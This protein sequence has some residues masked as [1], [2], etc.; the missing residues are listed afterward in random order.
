MNSGEHSFFRLY[1]DE[2]FEAFYDADPVSRRRII[3]ANLM[4]NSLPLF[5]MLAIFRE[6]LGVNLF[7]AYLLYGGFILYLFSSVETIAY[8]YPRLRYWYKKLFPYLLFLFA[9]AG[10]PLGIFLAM[11]GYS[12]GSGSETVEL[13]SFLVGSYFLSDYPPPLLY[14][15]VMAGIAVVMISIGI[16]YFGQSLILLA[17]RSLYMR[18]AEIETDVRFAK[19][20]QERLLAEVHLS[21]KQF[22]AAARSIPANALG[23][24]FF[25]LSRQGSRV[26][27]AVG[28]ISGHS[29]GAGLLMAMCKSALTTHL[30][31]TNSLSEVMKGLNRQLFSQSDRRMFATMLLMEA[32]LESNTITFCNAGHP[33]L[34]QLKS[35]KAEFHAGKRGL[36]L[37]MTPNAEWETETISLEKDDIF[38]LYSDGFIEIRDEKGEILD[39]SFFGPLVEELFESTAASAGELADRLEQRVR[40]LDSNVQADDDRTVII[41]RLM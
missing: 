26:I 36:A 16:T 17:S 11:L 28:D 34:L 22:D 15:E 12:L 1:R 4:L 8:L 32:D 2:E 14:S 27:A 29:F 33:S 41:L 13:P 9:L 10:V 38:V 30:S 39:D 24:D 7:T 31:Y 37:G 25:E 23:G 21:D 19:E 40:Q 3:L 18:R 5:V 6:Y 35:G 20:V